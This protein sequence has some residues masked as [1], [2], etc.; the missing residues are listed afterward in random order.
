LKKIILLILC[1]VVLLSGCENLPKAEP[2]YTETRDDIVLNTQF[3][4]YFTDEGS[5][6]CTWVNNGPEK[7]SFHDVFELHVLGNDGEWYGVSKNDEVSFNTD[8][9]HG[10]DPESESNARYN[11]SVYADKLENGKNYRI[12]TYFY[13]ADGNHYQ[14][15]SEF[16]CDDKLAEE[17][18]AE[19]SNGLFDRRDDPSSD[20]T[21]QILEKEG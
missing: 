6:R 20:G 12:S 11:I 1:F 5:I 19:A 7:F 3:D 10:I 21:L 18:M 15:Y 13:D 16:I 8:Y 17:E 9:S 2:Y 4:Y 14:I